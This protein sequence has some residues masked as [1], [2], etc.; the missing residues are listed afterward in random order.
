VSASSKYRI[1]TDW[2]AGVSTT[3]PSS[4]GP[5][6]RNLVDPPRP[7][8]PGHEWVWF[9]EGYWAEREVRG[10]TSPNDVKQRWWNRSPAQKSLISKSHSSTKSANEN[11][12]T[13]A[14]ANS[15][16]PPSFILPQIKIGS[17]SL[18]STARTSRR[19][20]QHTSES[21]SQKNTN[22][23]R[24]NPIKSGKEEDSE[25]AR[26]REGLYYRTKRNIEARFRKRVRA[27]SI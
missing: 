12:N 8:K 3:S 17:I 14:D 19:T 9:P 22:L 24:F 26:Q 1:I 6:V 11:R 4:F 27:W 25:S 5:P 10:Y 7:A 15:K 20:S 2:S 13:D 16:R 18:K 21:Q 23:W